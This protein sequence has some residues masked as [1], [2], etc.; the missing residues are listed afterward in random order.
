M[1]SKVK[2]SVSLIF[3]VFIAA[4][5]IA[6]ITYITIRYTPLIMS[7]ITRPKK[8]REFL[9]SYGSASI[10]VYIVFQILHV[11]IILIPG[12]FIQIAAGYIYGTFMGTVYSVIGIFI[13]MVI[14]FYATRIFG[15]KLIKIL[16]PPK[17]LEKYSFLINN[18]K[19]EII[20][21]V[22]FLIPGIPKDALTYISGLTPIKPHK[23]LII[24]TL[25]RFPGILGSSIIGANIMKRHFVTVSIISAIACGLFI[26]GILLRDKIIDKLHKVITSKSLK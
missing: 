14:V 8:F 15:Y 11:A 9:L 3:Y 26:A 5:F 17:K 13:G 2:V 20:I 22:L 12:E 18:P 4:V 24:A 16:I 6:F 19:Y 25:A 7:V 1:K 21:F 10:L 23:F